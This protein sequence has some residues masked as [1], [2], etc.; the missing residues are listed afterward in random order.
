MTFDH[1]FAEEG[2]QLTHWKNNFARH[3]PLSQGEA[4]ESFFA[5]AEVYFIGFLWCSKEE[6]ERKTQ[7]AAGDEVIHPPPWGIVYAGLDGK[8]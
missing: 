5:L 2:A 1:P 7:K 4:F 6:G 3:L 8:S